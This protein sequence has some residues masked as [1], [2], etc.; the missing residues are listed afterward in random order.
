[1]ESVISKPLE[2]SNRKPI[3]LQLKRIEAGITA[4]DFASALK[5]SPAKLSL[6]ENQHI[7]PEHWIKEQSARILNIPYE[8]LWE[9]N[10]E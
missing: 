5:I 9:G 10:N 1:M 7:E 2:P 3:K 4:L 8:E 6:I